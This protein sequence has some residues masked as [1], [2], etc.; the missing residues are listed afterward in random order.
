MEKII[1]GKTGLE[2]TPIFYGG[3]V[4]MNDGQE[5]S[6]NKTFGLGLGKSKTYDK[7]TDI[8]V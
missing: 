7:F 4:S 8:K 5:N 6:D 3:I 2:I 1:L